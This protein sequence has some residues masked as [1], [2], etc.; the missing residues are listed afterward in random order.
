MTRSD[1]GAHS[2]SS[3][4]TGTDRADAP[5]S[6]PPRATSPAQV[7]RDEVVSREKDRYGG[8]KIGSAFFG[9]LTAIGM[10]LLLTALLAAAGTAVGL[11]T[12]TQVGEAV[13]QATNDPGTV[14]VAGAI[15]LGVILFLAY[16]CGGYVAG[17]M[18]R[19][20]G[21]RQ[22]V[23]VWLWAVLIAVAVAIL[24]A[25]AGDEYDVLA[26]LNSVPR[27]PV[28]EGDVST[29]GLVALA[30]VAVVSLVGA[31]LGGLAGMR[32]HRKVD[33]AGLGR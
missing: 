2:A 27:V 4:D 17:R 28:N 11:A 19:F 22:G 29:A 13:D 6:T 10:A 9:W 25:I 33:R 30:I 14:G 23:A 26:R 3:S 20:N 7:D 16:Y 18:A 31:I 32:F 21:A 12:D 15:A 24:G 1:S 5:R 8:I